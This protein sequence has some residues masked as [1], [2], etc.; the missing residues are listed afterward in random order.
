M[1]VFVSYRRSDTEHLAG[2]IADRLRNEPEIEEVFFDID[3]IMPGENFE[4]KIDAALAESAICLVI[5]GPDWCGKS[6]DGP[7]RIFDESDF[8]RRETRAVLESDTKALPVLANDADMPG[9]DAVP[10]DLRSLLRINAVTVEFK[11]F[12]R[13]MDNLI[14]A[15]L[16]REK[17]SR[18]KS[19][20][21]R[22]P[23]LA[24]G[25]RMLGGTVLAAAALVIAAIIHKQTAGGSLDETLGRGPVWLLIIVVL[26]AGAVAPVAI[27]KLR[28]RGKAR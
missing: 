11:S 20:A 9:E 1:K 19:F 18:H 10:E 2:R 28:E 3:G 27:P 4:A 13:D 14:D 17:P 22:N 24:M 6:S 25:S 16:S 15:V 5:M 21:E 8:V 7:A 23:I 26:V 12:E